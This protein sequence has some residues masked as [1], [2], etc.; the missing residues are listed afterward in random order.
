MLKTSKIFI[1]DIDPKKIYDKER[2]DLDPHDT[3]DAWALLEAILAHAHDIDIDKLNKQYD[4]YKYKQ[5][6]NGNLVKP[7]SRFLREDYI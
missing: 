4:L 2:N 3:L 6:A 5:Q 7:L 1:L